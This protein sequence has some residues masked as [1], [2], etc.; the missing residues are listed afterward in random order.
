MKENTLLVKPRSQN[1]ISLSFSNANII[2]F[3]GRSSIEFLNQLSY[4]VN[5]TFIFI[6][7]FIFKR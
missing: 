6:A 7:I 3:Y 2:N 1:L 4:C 5:F